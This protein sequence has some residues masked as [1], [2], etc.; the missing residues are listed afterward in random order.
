VCV[1]V[2]VFFFNGGPKVPFVTGLYLNISYTRR[3]VVQV[4]FVVGCGSG[5]A[6]MSRAGRDA[7][8]V[9]LRDATAVSPKCR[10]RLSCTSGLSSRPQ[11][12]WAHGPCVCPGGFVCSCVAAFF[13]PFSAKKGLFFSFLFFLLALCHDSFD[14]THTSCGSGTETLV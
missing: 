8:H 5:F 7:H 12:R 4:M 11:H 3:V 14:G 10:V 6:V 9:R 2:R 1:C 13:D